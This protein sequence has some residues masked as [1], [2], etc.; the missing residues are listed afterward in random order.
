MDQLAVPEAA[1][2][3]RRT[4]TI[5]I[6]LLRKEL[7]SLQQEKETLFDKLTDINQQYQH[8]IDSFDHQIL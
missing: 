6:S 8:K 7:E 2:R 3:E 5:K 4:K 1:R